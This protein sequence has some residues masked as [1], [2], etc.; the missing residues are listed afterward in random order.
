MGCTN[1]ALQHTTEC[2]SRDNIIPD[3]QCLKYRYCRWTRLFLKSEAAHRDEIAG[4]RRSMRELAWAL[5]YY[6]YRYY[7][8]DGIDVI[9][10]EE[11]DEM[12]AELTYLE[13]I[14]PEYR[15]FLSPIS[16]PETQL[17]RRSFGLRYKLGWC[18]VCQAPAEINA[19]CR[20]PMCRSL[21]S[22]DYK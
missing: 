3:F 17:R 4:V 5:I 21:I 6:K 11:Y 9:S 18:K 14:H 16:V 12:E 19:D 10:D 8:G 1:C 15:S 7:Q 2:P 22:V 20:C 13:Y